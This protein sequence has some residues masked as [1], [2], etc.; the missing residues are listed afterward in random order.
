MMETTGT[1]KTTTARKMG[2]VF[3][4]M[5][6]LSAVEVVECSASDLIGSYVGQTGPKTRAQLEKALGKVL[7]VDEA[8]RLAEG[9]F[10]TEAL[11]ELVDLLT[12]P[13]FMDKIVVILAGYD[14]DINNL[15]SGNQGL[16]SRFP[17]QIIFRDMSPEHCIA[18]LKRS[19]EDEGIQIPRSLTNP[20]SKLHKELVALLTQTAS[21][22][23]WGNARDVKTLANTM[24]GSVFRTQASTSDPLSISANGILQHTK[25]M[26]Q[27]R[28]DRCTNLPSNTT[29]GLIPRE[30]PQQKIQDRPQPPP[31]ST[32][33]TTTTQA[34]KKSAKRP[35]IDPIESSPPSLP[36][37]DTN[38]SVPRDPGVPDTIWL[39]LQADLYAQQ[40][41]FQISPHDIR[42]GE[43]TLDAALATEES[44]HLALKLL[45][46]QAQTAQD[47]ADVQELKQRQEQARLEERAAREAREKAGRELERLRVE[48]VKKMREERVMVR[49]REMG[50]CVAGFEWVRQS[51]GYRCKGGWHFVSNGELG[52]GE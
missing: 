52:L 14:K 41:R 13:T 8:Y 44:K 43:S 36:H 46:E 7:F 31:M 2:Q 50:V 38:P 30:L 5:G 25:T 45:D 16:A 10:A 49:L 1:G 21:L 28:M 37:Q 4:D 39:Q 18:V 17:E 34:T 20:D 3:Y 9:P 33:A 27:E 51:G 23:S 32:A 29:T 22:P 24:I 15:I 26:V 48:E 42:K 40:I 11:N 12:K 19:I 35:R 47:E 6:F